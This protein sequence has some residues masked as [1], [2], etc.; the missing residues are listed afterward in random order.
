MRHIIF[1]IA[2]VIA[3]FSSAQAVVSCNEVKILYKNYDNLVAFGSDSSYTDAQI[4]VIGGKYEK[5]SDGYLIKPNDDV[6]ELE[7]RF[8]KNSNII[9]SKV[10]SCISLP[11]PE[12][13][14]GVTPVQYRPAV[15]DK[16]LVLKSKDVLCIGDVKYRINDWKV[17]VGNYELS[18]K[19]NKLSDEV[20]MLIFAQRSSKVLVK[21]HVNYTSTIPL[22]GTI[23]GQFT[24]TNPYFE[25]EI[26]FQDVIIIDKD[27][28]NNILFDENNPFSLLRNIISGLDNGYFG[29][30]FIPLTEQQANRIDPTKKMLQA[31]LL[32][33][34]DVS[35]A[36][37]DTLSIEFG[38]DKTVFNGI[39]YKYQ[40]P[41]R[42]A[43][44]YDTKDITRLI[45]FKSEFI[46]AQ[47]KQLTTTI[48]HIGLAKKYNNQ[49][50]FDIVSII[51]FDE[52]SSYK[53]ISEIV[54]ENKSPESYIKL[55]DEIN[56]TQTKENRL[57]D[58]RYYRRYQSFPFT[59][60]FS[61]HNSYIPNNVFDSVIYY[62][63]TTV[64]DYDSLGNLLPSGKY[65]TRIDTIVY[66][67]YANSSLIKPFFKYSRTDKTSF[68]RSYIIYAIQTPK[69]L[70]S[71]CEVPL[72]DQPEPLSKI[73][74]R[75]SLNLP[76]PHYR[77]SID[78]FE[79]KKEL[80]TVLSGKRP[81]DLTNKKDIKLLEKEFYL[82]TYKGIPVNILGVCYGSK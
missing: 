22:S 69:G 25:N 9:Y 29:Y 23:T 33:E 50:K 54:V 44:Y 4:T 47:T 18:G 8:L 80:R 46:D 61:D 38:E 17:T 77:Y 45:F 19:G 79:W 10:F 20:Q 49:E 53:D 41:E 11:E 70:F 75:G 31:R 14:W 72:N 71:Y 16:L 78:D 52:I 57:A 28:T 42:R 59:N 36:N 81:Y 74:Y 64:M 56:K 63:D 68:E 2:V 65:I 30:K 27:S 3:F 73:M 6:A 21:I 32:S 60:L 15:E 35:L 66:N 67:I 62:L 13:F 24:V 5:T 55:I 51:P 43:I 58:F 7:I 39:D 34:S 48:S 1:L 37:D 40:Y 12:L 82:D 76:Y 26:S